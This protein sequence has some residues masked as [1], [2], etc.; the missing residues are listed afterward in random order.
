MI[1]GQKVK[2]QLFSFEV[3][4]GSGSKSKPA[5]QALSLGARIVLLVETPKERRKWGEGGIFLPSSSPFP[6]FNLALDPKGRF[7]YPPH[8]CSVIKT[9]VAATTILT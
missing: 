5:V 4:R 9:K 6:S 2:R 8:C 3:R 7:F 1:L